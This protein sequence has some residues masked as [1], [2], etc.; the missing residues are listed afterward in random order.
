MRRV[1]L[2]Y[3]TMTIKIII[4]V[5]AFVQVRHDLEKDRRKL[6]QELQDLRNQLAE[7]KQKIAELEQ[8][9]SKKESELAAALKRSET[10][11]AP[12][13]VSLALFRKL[14]LIKNSTSVNVIYF[15]YRRKGLN[16]SC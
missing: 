1:E 7:A 5:F 3:Q 10:F 8:A 9:L 12:I 11:Y 15:D 4:C 6:E 16:I 2:G 14:C 13:N